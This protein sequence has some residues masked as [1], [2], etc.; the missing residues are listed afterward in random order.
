VWDLYGVRFSRSLRSEQGWYT[1]FRTTDTK[2]LL[3]RQCK[4]ID[5]QK[6]LNRFALRKTH[7]QFGKKA[8]NRR[9]VVS[10][11]PFHSYALTASMVGGSWYN[12]CQTVST[13]CRVDKLINKRR[14]P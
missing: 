5:E 12:V 1:V 14:K 13:D 4:E 9:L 8:G 11:I 6:R 2:Y 7:P 3:R 10:P